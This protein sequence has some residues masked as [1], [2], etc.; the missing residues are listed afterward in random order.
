MAP[1]KEIFEGLGRFF[2]DGMESL[3]LLKILNQDLRAEEGLRVRYQRQA[4]A[5]RSPQV[6]AKLRELAEG[7]AEHAALLTKWIRE[8]GG[9]PNMVVEPPLPSAWTI[10]QLL[11]QDYEEERRLYE[12]YLDQAEIIEIEGLKALFQKIGQEEEG[13]LKEL[14]EL[15]VRYS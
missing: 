1:L 6:A 15:Y 7:E 13:H 14:T 4:Q 10:G 8:L 9:E 12:A 5:I 3:N 2:G 11:V